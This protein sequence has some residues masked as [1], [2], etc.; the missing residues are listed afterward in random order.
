MPE[1]IN[2]HVELEKDIL[3]KFYKYAT[4]KSFEE[5]GFKLNKKQMLNYGLKVLSEIWEKELTETKKPAE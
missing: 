5:F 4:I 2:I 3:D 1:T